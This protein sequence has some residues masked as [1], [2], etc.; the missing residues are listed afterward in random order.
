MKT[1]KCLLPLLLVVTAAPA[2]GDSI[3]PPAILSISMTGLSCDIGSLNSV[4]YNN[5]QASVTNHS[6]LAFDG[7]IQLHGDVTSFTFTG[8]TT[9][10][11]L[12]VG[13]F[14]A[15]EI[16]PGPN[17]GLYE[18][19]VSGTF[20]INW[21]GNGSTTNIGQINIPIADVTYIGRVGTTPEPGTLAL[22]GTGLCGIVGLVRRKLKTTGQVTKD[23]TIRCNDERRTASV[24]FPCR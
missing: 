21:A 22:M 13:T 12:F 24:P 9:T 17:Q 14:S 1:F 18:Y 20:S 8:S 2:L 7:S 19:A 4:C 6:I 16:L 11:G 23:R 15:N 5:G 3:P 10:G